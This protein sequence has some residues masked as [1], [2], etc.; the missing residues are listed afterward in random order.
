MTES[1][2]VYVLPSNG[3]GAIPTGTNVATHLRSDG[4]QIQ[5]VYLSTGSVQIVDVH[6]H[7]ANIQHVSGTISGD[8]YGIVT[9]AIIHGRSTAGGGTFVDV[10]VSPSGAVQVG[11][12]IDNIGKVSVVSSGNVTTATIS[13]GTSYT[14][15]WEQNDYPDVCVSIQSSTAGTL[16]FDFSP[17]G[18]N[19]N[20]F[21][22][23]GFPIT[24]GIHNFRV[25]VKASRYFRAR[26]RNEGNGQTYL[27]LYT[28]YGTFRHPNAPLNT[29]I[30]TSQ[31][32]ILT[33]SVLTGETD[34]GHFLNVPVD[35][36][37]HVE[38][39]VHSPK[40][41]FGSIWTEKR[42]PLAQAD[43]VYGL[44]TDKISATTGLSF[45]AGV[46]SGLVTGTNGEIMC[47][48]GNTPFS[49]ATFQTN[50]RLRYIPGQGIISEFTM[51]FS[52][53][54]DGT[55]MGIGIGSAESG[56][57]FAYSGTA[58]GTLY[59]TNGIR[60]IQTL[61]I[62]TGSAST[63][64]Y[65]LTLPGGA[66]VTGTNATNNTS[67]IRTSYEISQMTIPG[68][69]A[70]QI[71]STVIFLADSADN[72]SG[73][74]SITQ[75]A[76]ATRAVG[77]TVV[78]RD[79]QTATNTWQWQGDWTG[80]KFNGTGT[81][82]VY[83]DKQKGNIGKINMQYLGYG[84]IS[85]EIEVSPSGNN[86]EFVLANVV[87]S[88]NSRTSPT[89]TN[90]S[91]PIT[92]FAYSFGSS[93]NVSVSCASMA[94][95]MEG[96]K[97]LNGSRRTYWRETNNFV[98]SATGTFYP[99]V[100]VRNDYVFKGKANQAVI[101]LISMGGGHDDATPVYYFLIKNPT[102]GGV[103][104]F[105]RFTENSPTSWDIA[106]TTASITDNSQII[107][108]LPLGDASGDTVPFGENPILMQPGDV[109]CLAAR[110]VT[111]TAPYVLGTLNAREDV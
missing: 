25:A 29:T 81:S 53:P 4:K 15:T 102:L 44:N 43:G 71:D 26:F 34:G 51:R 75:S 18:S 83:L 100:T 49:F 8:E 101:N 97:K 7:V 2:V 68:W 87:V 37:G 54:S 23:T 107:F 72:K 47:Q 48:T 88:P 38:V 84:D 93:N 96:D 13:S 19:V 103:P 95:F 76:G 20:T 85:Q 90:P 73:T 30:S 63:N 46:S 52:E 89:L 14:G 57:Y 69:S 56:V 33:R 91:M 82:G 99:I 80:D 58:F 108:S 41:P 39:A 5:D 105:Q 28:Y 59:V 24:A 111:A 6:G 78:T 40:N 9:N 66:V 65:I 27:R 64:N 35:G 42:T 3:G 21:P 94:G 11:G 70:Q 12:T 106:A 61:T 67:T 45:G 16:Y 55:L 17:D 79:G 109:Y 60:E 74:F 36:N 86:P 110:A 31:D 10:K 77:T 50:E 62:T 32:A 104:N 22:S 98:G 1:S 92:A